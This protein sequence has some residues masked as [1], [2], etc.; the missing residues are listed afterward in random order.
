M[1]RF[2]VSLRVSL[3]LSAFLLV[4]AATSSPTPA[5]ADGLQGLRLPV[6]ELLVADGQV[7]GETF[8]MPTALPA[9]LAA[10]R[11]GDGL[12]LPELPVAPGLR[13][14]V[15]LR[16]VDIYAAGARLWHVDGDTVQEVPRTEKRYFLGADAADP[17]RRVGLWLEPS[18]RLGGVITGPE[19][20]FEL[21][22]TASGAQRLLKLGQDTPKLEAGCA[23]SDQEKVYLPWSDPAWLEPSTASRD[24]APAPAKRG[25]TPTYQAV[26][27]VDTDTEMMSLAFKN[28]T[29]AAASW[30][31]DLF[32]SMNVFYERD[33][34]TSLVQG[35]TF[36]RTESDSYSG[37]SGAS[38]AQ[39]NEFASFWSTNYGAVDRVFAMLL[40][41]KSSSPFSASGIAYVAGG[42]ISPGAGV[43]TYC[44]TSSGYSVNQVFYAFGASAS[45]LLV[46]HEIG[47]NAGS[48]HTHCYVP[49]IDMCFGQE[50]LC[51]GGPTS[52]PMEGS[53]T[54]MSYC[55]FSSGCGTTSRLEF[56]PRVIANIGFNIVASH[57][58]CIDDY[59]NPE[60]FGDGFESGDTSRWTG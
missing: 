1:P 33:L 22:V 52:C 53:G 10:T 6:G 12:R 41:G 29:S 34:D 38:A 49:A 35:E 42:G 16:H 50:F 60:I 37:G 31:G 9:A 32:T 2:A 5:A 23:L 44:S 24:S 4:C 47:H 28:D 25:A 3:R 48:S 7:V 21:D 17:S 40:S 36:F 14:S 45:A 46:G 26:I 11:P 54:I 43:A 8:D 15:E 20:T 30:I 56:H 58:E 55:N 39:L 18:G 19:G 27:A 51:Y 13:R 57:P 59:E